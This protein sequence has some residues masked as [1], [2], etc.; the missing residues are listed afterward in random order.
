MKIV[1][2][3][4]LAFSSSA[5]SA[6]GRFQIIPNHKDDSLTALLDTQTG[7]IWVRQCVAALQGGCYKHMWAIEP[8][9]GITPKAESLEYIQSA[10][11]SA[12]SISKDA[13]L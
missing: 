5:F 12:E 13:G 7:K 2:F 9:M 4:L 11:K 8:V 1:L 10:T 3:M 6:D